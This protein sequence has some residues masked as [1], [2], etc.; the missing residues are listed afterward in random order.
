METQ[1]PGSRNDEEERK[2]LRIG[3]P[4]GKK[5]TKKSK[6]KNG[7][8][9]VVSLS[10]LRMFPFLWLKRERDNKPAQKNLQFWQS[11]YKAAHRDSKKKTYPTEKTGSCA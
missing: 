7:R 11:T 10:L 2:R 5:I 9:C 6:V 8:G 1:E 4:T 3:R